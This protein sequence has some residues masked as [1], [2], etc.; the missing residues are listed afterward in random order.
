M[1]I[2]RNLGSRPSLVIGALMACIAA[3]AALLTAAWVGF[4]GSDDME[5]YLAGRALSTSFWNVP[6]GFG[7]MRSAVSVPIAISLRVFGDREWALIVPTC[8]YSLATVAVTFLSLARFVVLPAAIVPTMLFVSLPVM[9]TTSTM[10]AADVAELFWGVCAFWLAV[11]SLGSN[12]RRQTTLMISSG[13]CIALAFASRETSAAM[14]I[15][16][17]MGFLLGYGIP[18]LKYVWSAVGFLAVMAL[19]CSYF[20]ASAG[21]PFARLRAL[22]ATR[23]HVSRMAVPPFTFDDT[24]NLRIHD[25]IDPFIMLVSKHSF[26]ALYWMFLALL[27][28]AW[29]WRRR[30]GTFHGPQRR[31][32]QFIVPALVLGLIWAVFAAAALASLRIHARY[33][34]APTYFVLVAVSLWLVGRYSLSHWRRFSLLAIAI[35]AS[36]NLL[37]TWVDNRNPRFAERSLADLAMRYREPIHTDEATAYVASAFLH[38]RGGQAGQIVFTPPAPGDLRFRIRSGLGRGALQRAAGAGDEQTDVVLE[39]LSSPPLLGGTLAAAIGGSS[40]VPRAITSKLTSSRSSAEL[41]RVGTS[42]GEDQISAR[43]E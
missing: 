19:E 12:S 37:G 29:I 10:A 21:D 13:A 22:G 15:W 30:D 36:T 6:D 5:Y 17:A 28:L 41:L 16:L 25:L 42:N 23:S 38:W 33:Y 14:I 27:V 8:L 2:E 1:L 40:I 26:G 18:R 35:L 43:R 3:A 9:A 20:A 7:G 31:A 32:D 24:G 39:R 11:E 34:L 4:I